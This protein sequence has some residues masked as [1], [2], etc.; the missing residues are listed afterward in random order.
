MISLPVVSTYISSNL[1]SVLLILLFIRYI[2]SYNKSK[3]LPKGPYGLPL[4]GYLPFLGKN[5]HYTLWKLSKQYGS[6]YTLP[7]GKQNIVVLND[8]DSIKDSLRKDSFLG[9]NNSFSIFTGVKSLIDDSKKSWRED[10]RVFE[11]IFQTSLNSPFIY[12]NILLELRYLLIHLR[13]TND[14]SIKLHK[15]LSKFINKLFYTFVFGKQF[16]LSNSLFDASFF[17]KISILSL[18]PSWMGRLFY[19]IFSHYRFSFFDKIF[20]TES[21]LHYKTLRNEISIRDLIDGYLLELK[22]RRTSSL[23]TTM[24]IEKLRANC[25]VFLSFGSEAFLSSLEWCLI[26]VAYYQEYQQKIS[27][28]IELVVGK[29][30]FPNFRDQIRMPFTVAFLNEVLRWKTVFPFNF[31]RRA[32]EDATI[33]GHF[34]P[35][36]T[37]ILSN[38]WAVHH[39]PTIWEDPFKFNPY[40]FL[41]DNTKTLIDHEG[42]M[43]FS[44]GKRSCVAEPFVRKLL[45]LYIVSIVQK[46]TVTTMNR[47]EVFDEEF[48]ITIKPKGQVNL[49]FQYKAD[50][51][52]QEKGSDDL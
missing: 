52:Y 16:L 17:V 32:V 41:S 8:W 48:N 28:E 10:R 45:F 26:S 3:R 31:T 7:L 27:D 33:M 18:Y 9:K 46:F 30:R 50:T 20:K 39:D 12:K 1:S 51:D 34:I 6:I 49:V 35:K 37:L 5:P 29:Q 25:Q 42:Y 47:D 4:I 36:D 22:S 19:K 44:I 43:P 23:P 14:R 40:R 21:K 11:N 38:I 15:N 2:I 24:S 13:K